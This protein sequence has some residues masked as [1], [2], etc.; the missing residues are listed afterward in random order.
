MQ[1]HQAQAIEELDMQVEQ[2]QESFSTIL[3]QTE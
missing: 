1:I 2:K 3:K